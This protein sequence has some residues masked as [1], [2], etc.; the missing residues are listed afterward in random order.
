MIGHERANNYNGR[1]HS[2]EHNE[3]SYSA[4]ALGSS[5]A[6]KMGGVERQLD[7]ATGPRTIP[8]KLLVGSTLTN[9]STYLQLL[10]TVAHP[11]S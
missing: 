10:N 8:A 11:H 2:H 5:N 4:V 3:V 7:Y 6:P 1:G 9:D